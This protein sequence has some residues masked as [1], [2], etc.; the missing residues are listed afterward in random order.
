MSRPTPLVQVVFLRPFGVL[1]SQKHYSDW[2]EIQDEY[3]AYMSSLGPFTEE[4]LED[5]PACQ[6]GQ[7][8]ARRGFTREDVW[9]FMES[10]AT[11]LEARPDTPDGCAG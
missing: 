4:R 1:L 10:D 7:D 11:V 6:Y 9:R 5:F 3:A 8:D 2:R